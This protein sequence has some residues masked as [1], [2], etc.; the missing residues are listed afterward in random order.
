MLCGG[1]KKRIEGQIR[2]TV[3]HELAHH[4]GM[5]HERICARLDCDLDRAS[6]RN[7]SV[8]RKG[9]FMRRAVLVLVG[10]VLVA[11]CSVNVDRGGDAADLRK[12]MS[13]GRPRRR[14]MIWRRRFRFMRTTPSCCRGTHRSR[15]D[16]KAIREVWAGMLGPGTAVSW[17]VTKAE[18]AKSGE[19]VI[20]TELTN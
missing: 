6:T 17:K 7:G 10:A 4:L 3:L 15:A 11:G 1:D 19:W 9:G 20:S 18:V 2:K 16:K 5:S 8:E 14:R 12:L 13:S